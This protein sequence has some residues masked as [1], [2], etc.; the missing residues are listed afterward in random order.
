YMPFSSELDWRFAE[1]AVKDG[2]GQNATDRLLSVPGIREKLGLS[3][4]NMRALL[5]KVDSI[6]D[7]VGVWQERSLSF[8]SNPN[9]VYT[10]RFRDPVEAVKMLFA[11]P[12]FKMEIIYAPKKV[13]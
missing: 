13:Y 4:N 11:D 1:W 10:I 8:R 7:R 3:Y 9:D 6:P 2:P 12:A 5:Q